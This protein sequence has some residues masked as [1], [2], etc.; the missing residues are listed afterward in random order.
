VN[1]LLIVISGFILSVGSYIVWPSRKNIIA[2]VRL[3]FS[4]TSLIVPVY[5]ANVLSTYNSTL[6]SQYAQI[7]I[8]GSLF[9]L[10]GMY[11]GFTYKLSAKRLFKD[12][13]SEILNENALNYIKRYVPILTIFGILLMLVCFIGMGFIP[14]FSSD[15]FQAKFFRGDYKDA[16]QPFAFP[17]RVSYQI[18]SLCSVINLAVFLISRKNIYLMLAFLC[19]A[20]LF[21]TLTRGP[22]IYAL[23]LFFGCLSIFYR[24]WFWPYILFIVLIYPFGSLFY[25]IFGT[26]FGIDQFTKIYD[27][28]SIWNSIASGAP[29]ITD[30]L[31]FLK[32]FN[33]LGG[34]LTYGKTYFGGLI[35]YNFF[36][37]PAVYSLYIVNNGLMDI[38]SLG[39]GGVRVG[40]PLWGYSSFSWLGVVFTSLISG[41]FWGMG[42][43]VI[44]QIT[45]IVSKTSFSKEY[46]A[47]LLLFSIVVYENVF[48]LF[49]D[50]Y[51][52]SLYG[53]ASLSIVLFLLY[54]NR[55][56]VSRLRG[57]LKVK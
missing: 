22:M 3:G 52:S 36:W 18:I 35:P 1:E 43:K 40:L 8:I 39:S 30:Q 57:K 29:D 13:A 23:I 2:H 16:Y 9:Y 7:S 31:N 28:T 47:G 24:K 45:N 53:I 37:N 55:F 38:S 27:V 50:F 21:L 15:P 46:K 33:G 34:N 49:S 17:Y 4:I 5:L 32:G 54:G 26:I 14:A 56:S 10:F 51:T 42:T 48:R 20:F 19:S 11:L 6:I 44:K 25:L 12:V 41:T